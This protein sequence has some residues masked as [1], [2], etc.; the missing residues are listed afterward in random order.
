MAAIMDA[1]PRILIPLLLEKL[2]REGAQ[3]M[4]EMGVKALREYQISIKEL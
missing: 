4:L 2:K 3:D 1:A